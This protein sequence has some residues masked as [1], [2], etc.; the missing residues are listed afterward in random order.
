MLKK[1]DKENV[2]D[3][4][5]YVISKKRGFSFVAFILCILIAFSVWL[6]AEN[7]ERERVSG[8]ETASTESAYAETYDASVVL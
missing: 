7:R 1:K 4:G 2:Y 5:S 6:F 3:D 8:D